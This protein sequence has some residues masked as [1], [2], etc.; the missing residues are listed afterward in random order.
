MI[1]WMEN[2]KKKG[3]LSNMFNFKSIAIVALLYGIIS[4]QSLYANEFKTDLDKWSNDSKYIDGVLFIEGD[5]GADVLLKEISNCPYE[6]CKMEDI[7]QEELEEKKHILSIK[8][9]RL[10]WVSHFIKATHVVASDVV[11][12][13]LK[14]CKV[15]ERCIVK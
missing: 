13:I 10:W 6:K 8:L 1:I 7:D 4:S 15:A 5:K 11:I 3:V 14:I 2:S 12:D 9:A